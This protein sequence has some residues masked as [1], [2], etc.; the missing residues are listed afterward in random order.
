MHA[1]CSITLLSPL[2]P[3]DYIIFICIAPCSALCTDTYLQQA[4][5]RPLASPM[6]LLHHAG[7]FGMLG[8][9]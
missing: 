8:P 2:P 3:S 6:Q 5:D 1:V 7:D 9:L 4:N